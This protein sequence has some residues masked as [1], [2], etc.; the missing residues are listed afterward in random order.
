VNEDPTRMALLIGRNRKRIGQDESVDMLH[1][2]SLGGGSRRY[3]ARAAPR[4]TEVGIE[5]PGGEPWLV[6]TVSSCCVPFSR[7]CCW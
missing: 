2:G 1:D 7:Q 6:S 5:P 4:Q 3:A